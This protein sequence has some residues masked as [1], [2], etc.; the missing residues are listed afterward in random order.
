MPSAR[1]STT[2]DSTSPDPAGSR[3]V[4]GNLFVYGTLLLP[5]V[6]EALIDRVPRALAAT[7]SGYGRHRLI[8]KVYPAIAVEPAARVDGLVYRGL[9]RGERMILDAFE[10][11]MYTRR[12]V[13]AHTRPDEVVAADAYVVDDDHPRLVRHAPP[14]SLEQF[15]AHSSVAY[16]RMCAEFQARWR[17]IESH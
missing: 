11:S 14:W 3:E 8:G 17:A 6:I 16:I 5:A 15:T 1:S 9:D 7:L 4:D 13:H 2:G 12:R 10:G